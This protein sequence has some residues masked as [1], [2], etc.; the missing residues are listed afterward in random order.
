[1]ALVSLVPFQGPKKSQFSGPTPSNA[2]RN[3]VA[4]LKTITY[5]A[6]KTT[7]TLIVIIS[8]CVILEKVLKKGSFYPWPS[9]TCWYITGSPL[10]P[11][12]SLTLEPL[13]L[14]HSVQLPAVWKE[15]FSKSVQN[16]RSHI[17]ATKYLTEKIKHVLETPFLCCFSI[18]RMAKDWKTL[19]SH[20]GDG[21]TIQDAQEHNLHQFY[22]Q[23]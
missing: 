12:V 6:I 1:M 2:P 4:H 8:N 10:I 3:C 17:L 20:C 22:Q 13:F 15:F 18:Y 19:H 14:G 23:I 11:P 21:G 7:G 5:H 16:R 9:H